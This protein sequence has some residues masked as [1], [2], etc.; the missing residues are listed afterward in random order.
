VRTLPRVAAEPLPTIDAFGSA[1]AGASDPFSSL[2]NAPSTPSAADVRAAI[3]S[4][5][6]TPSQ[7][8][9]PPTPEVRAAIS[10]FLRRN[11][12]AAA[13]ASA[14][15]A[16]S[17]AAIELVHDGSISLASSAIEMPSSPK[18]VSRRLVLDEDVSDDEVDGG[19]GGDLWTRSGAIAASDEIAG[20]PLRQR[21]QPLSRRR[22]ERPRRR[23]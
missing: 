14:A 9:A 8:D 18:A 5:V 6:P 11:G 16:A 20:A 15:R 1:S 7:A 22:D 13:T 19:G 21:S 23:R 3:H 10:S 17:D 2:F 4:F 12:R